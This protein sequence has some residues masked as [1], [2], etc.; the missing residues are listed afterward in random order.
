MTTTEPA[1]TL[2]SPRVWVVHYSH[3]HGDDITACTSP[4]AADGIAAGLARDYWHELFEQGDVPAGLPRDAG[5]L[6]DGEVRRLYFAH[7]VGEACTITE[8]P[9]WPLSQ[10]LPGTVAAVVRHAG[11]GYG[12]LA[13]TLKAVLAR[14][15]AA[16]ALDFIAGVPEG[17]P[18]CGC[19]G[20]HWACT[21]TGGGVL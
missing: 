3:R 16:A 7:R 14:P 6:P 11:E 17:G 18:S 10:G 20:S 19:G 8:E 5:G 21:E 1:V 13:D 9:L 15:D 12:A 2:A 4:A